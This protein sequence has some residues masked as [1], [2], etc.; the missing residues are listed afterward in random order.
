MR[1]WLS[2]DLLL[3]KSCSPTISKSSII[4]L[5]SS[6]TSRLAAS[7]GVSFSSILPPGKTQQFHFFLKDCQQ[8]SFLIL[9]DYSHKTW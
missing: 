4:K 3:E 1:P 9:D 5:V 6:Q 8:F 2:G 7:S